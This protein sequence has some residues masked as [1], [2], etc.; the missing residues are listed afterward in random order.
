[1]HKASDKKAYRDLLLRRRH[2]SDCDSLG[3]GGRGL[4]RSGDRHGDGDGARHCRQEV[5]NMLSR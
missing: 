5:Q 4:G 3:R 2:N 1:M